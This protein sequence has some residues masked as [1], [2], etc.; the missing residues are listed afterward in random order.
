[1]TSNEHD[2]ESRREAE[3]LMREYGDARVNQMLLDWLHD[4]EARKK[5]RAE[6]TGGFGP[7]APEPPPQRIVVIMIE[8]CMKFV[9]YALSIAVVG[10][11]LWQLAGVI[12]PVPSTALA[13]IILLGYARTLYLIA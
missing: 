1:M 13:V 2:L 12:G 7:P 3:L 6:L 11:L 5:R 4:L 9:L 8:A 10:Y